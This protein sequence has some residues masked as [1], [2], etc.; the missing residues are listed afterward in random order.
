[1]S[2]LSSL[3]PI[4]RVRRVLA[5]L[6]LKD[7]GIDAIDA[8]EEEAVS[9]AIDKARSDALPDFMSALGDVYTPV[10]VAV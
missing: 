9:V 10:Q 4:A 3:D 8:A 1:M 2:E 6:G 7:A 5:A